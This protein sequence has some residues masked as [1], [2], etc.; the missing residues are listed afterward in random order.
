MEDGLRKEFERLQKTHGLDQFQTYND[1]FEIETIEETSYL[2]RAIRRKMMDR[3]EYYSDILEQLISGDSTIRN[4]FEYSH[5]TEADKKEMFELYKALMILQRDAAITALSCD[6]KQ[7]GR[8]CKEA[9]KAWVSLRPRLGAQVRK[10]R[11]SWSKDA[12]ANE[13]TGYFG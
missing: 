8:Y 3:F 7:E 12:S 11:D 1:E 9:L 5:L 10:M 13:A 2:L 6:E 4:L